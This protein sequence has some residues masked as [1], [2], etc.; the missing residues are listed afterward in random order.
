MV[1]TLFQQLFAVVFI[2]VFFGIVVA[3]DSVSSKRRD[4]ELLVRSMVGLKMGTSSFNA[5]RELAEAYG[6]KPT[7]GGPTG[8][9]CSAQAC[10]FTFVIDNRPL[11]Y[12]PGVSAVQFVATV[13]VKDGYVTERQIHYN[14]LN[15]T[16]GVDFAYFLIDHL[17]SHGFDVQKLKVDAEGMPHILKVNLGQSATADERRRAYSIELSCLAFRLHGCR[18]AAAV[19]PA[20][21]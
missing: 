4:A 21:L 6:G 10:T 18:R 2:I 17:D 14:I 3:V 11:S 20:G 12:I 9:R 7:S 16:G 15:R 19:F 13:G 8:E 5:A 1:R